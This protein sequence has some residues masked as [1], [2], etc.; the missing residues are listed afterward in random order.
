MIRV[1]ART[2]PAPAAPTT[3]TKSIE[4]LAPWLMSRS[5][6]EV[7][8]MLQD[9]HVPA[10]AVLSLDETLDDE[11]LRERGFWVSPEQLGAGARMPGLPFRL[12][13]SPSEFRPAPRLG[14]HTAEV[15]GEAGCTP[16]E[17]RRLVRRRRAPR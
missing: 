7:V 17:L 4:R 12:P 1:T 14:Q 9:H 2:R 6:G 8:E 13:S 16:H 10:S 3:P 15:L 5:R 11:Q